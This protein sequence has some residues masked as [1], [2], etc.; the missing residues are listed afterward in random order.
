MKLGFGF[1]R[2]QL[3]RE[4]Y[5]FAVQCGAT[6]GVVHLVDYF[7]QGSRIHGEDQPIGD[8]HGGWGIA[9]GTPAEAWSFESLCRLK[10]EMAGAG[11]TLEAIEN[12]DPAQW[13]DVLL[14]GPRKDEQIEHLKQI[15]RDVGAAGIPVFGYNF[16]IAGVAGRVSGTGARGGARTVGM[17]GP[18]ETNT[19]PIPKGMVWNMVYD[20]D[21]PAGTLPEIG[22]DELWS[23]LGYFLKELVPVAEQAGVR[24]AAHPDD[25][26]LPYVRRQPRLVHQPP[27][28]Q[29]LIDL[30]PS[31][32]NALEF[33]LGTLAEMT[34]GD[35]YGTCERHS[36]Q[37]DIAYIHFRNVRGKV[38]DYTETF[39]DE[40]DLDMRRIVEILRDTGFDGVLIPDHA[41]QMTCDAPWHAGMAYTMGYMKAL[42]G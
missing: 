2:H 7:H 1:Y 9:G 12:F 32:S 19:S 35:V 27:L 42:L 30:V 31:R 26:P 24:L 29:R 23:R 28:Y 13:H 3:R 11:L 40:G 17:R 38:P 37:G 8:L 34:E 20:P 4:S 18:E 33:C 39:I 21:A 25:P 5:D 36:R 15:I 14:D 6:H 16:S 41:P 10:D 22:H